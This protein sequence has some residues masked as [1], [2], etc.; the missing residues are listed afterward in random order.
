M[1]LIRASLAAPARRTFGRC[2]CVEFLSFDSEAQPCL[3]AR[4]LLSG[5][6]HLLSASAGKQPEAQP[7]QG[8]LHRR[9]RGLAGSLLQEFQQEVVSSPA[10]S[11][12]KARLT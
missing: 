12:T 4:S 11:R 2:L 1:L 6:P 9:E 7:C 8:T 3:A 5:S 10:Y